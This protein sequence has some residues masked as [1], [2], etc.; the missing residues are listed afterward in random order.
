VSDEKVV[1]DWFVKMLA[2]FRIYSPLY[3]VAVE[4]ERDGYC[5]VAWNE[6]NSIECKDVEVQEGAVVRWM[7]P[8]MIYRKVEAR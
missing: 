3:K 4:K 5:V 1:R 2:D 8:Q 7:H 6:L